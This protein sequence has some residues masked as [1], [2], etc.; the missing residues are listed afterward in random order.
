MYRVDVPILVPAAPS[1]VFRVIVTGDHT[2][3]LGTH[4]FEVP[5]PAARTDFARITID[6][7]MVTDSGTVAK[8]EQIK[9]NELA[10]II[11]RDAMTKLGEKAYLDSVRGQS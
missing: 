10:A 3:I 1:C 4:Y 2:R 8:V 7:E 9:A 6:V 11:V 5:L